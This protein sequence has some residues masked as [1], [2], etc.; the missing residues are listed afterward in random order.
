MNIS[1]IRLEMVKDKSIE[2]ENV[3]LR[4]SKDLANIG[5]KLLARSDR[6]VFLLVCLNTKNQIN[7]IQE[8][9]IGSLS[10]SIVHPREVYKLAILNNS[11]SVA[12]L[13]NHPS[14]S[15][16]PS[17]DDIEITKRLVEI[18]KL[19]GIKVLDHVIIGDDTY[20]S[21]MEKGTCGF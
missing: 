6:E 10:S 17:Q 5:F 9:S 1:L 3:Q 4:N 7:A 14:G 18:G 19:F 20:F 8:V 21:L 15:T 12:F 11:A 2:Y 13:H 16:D